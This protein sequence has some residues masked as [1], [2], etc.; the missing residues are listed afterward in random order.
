MSLAGQ[1]PTL[2]CLIGPPAVGK[3]TVGQELCRR[4]GFKLFHGHVLADVLARTWRQMFFEEALEAGLSLVITVAWRFD[5]PE[6]EETI[7]SWLQPYI[8]RGRVLCVELSAPLGG[9]AGTQPKRGPTTSEERLL[10]H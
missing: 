2:V 7:R 9:S 1:T 5:V 6:D 3:M 4:T 8:E 10:G